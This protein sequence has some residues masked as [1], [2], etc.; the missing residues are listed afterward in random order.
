MQVRTYADSD[1]ESVVRIFDAIWGWELEGDQEEKHTLAAHYIAAALA[2]SN[3]VRVA[4][5]E[6]NVVGIM[7]AA[8]DNLTDTTHRPDY[9]TYMMLVAQTRQTL[10]QTETGRETLAFY[11]DIDAINADLERSMIRQGQ[12]WQA[13]MKLL[14]CSPDCQGQGVGKHLVGDLFARLHREHVTWCML[15]TDTHCQWQYYEKTG[16][17]MAARQEWPGDSDMTAFAFCREVK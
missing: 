3:Y 13:E 8:I 14:I 17:L 12:D 6:G 5:H 10:E 1:F 16:W 9:A 7:C 2:G 11:K 15:K 4:E